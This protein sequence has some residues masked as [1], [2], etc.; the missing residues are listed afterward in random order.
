M[1]YLFHLWGLCILFLVSARGR[2]P[3]MYHFMSLCFFIPTS[4]MYYHKGII[5][6]IFAVAKLFEPILMFTFLVRCCAPMMYRLTSLVVARGMIFASIFSLCC[7]LIILA[8]APNN[9]CSDCSVVLFGL[10]WWRSPLLVCASFQC[11]CFWSLRD[12]LMPIFCLFW[13]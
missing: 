9:R 1:H 8:T 2:T 5:L 11:K 13:R 3:F 12:V 7:S 6:W 10:C 4:I